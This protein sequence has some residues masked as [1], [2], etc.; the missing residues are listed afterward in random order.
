MRAVGEIG[1]WA[2]GRRNRFRVEGDSMR[3]TLEDG[4]FVLVDPASEP[5]PGDLAV[6]RHPERADLAVVKR[7]VERLADGRYVLA[8]DD[9]DRGSDSRSWG[10]VDPALV[11]GRVTLALDRPLASLAEQPPPHDR[12]RTRRP[13][14]ARW[15]RR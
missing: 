13:R 8:S 3:P 1:C 14:W 12:G 4:W 15:L 11:Q 10:P 5:R 7:V 9:P 2:A 6:A